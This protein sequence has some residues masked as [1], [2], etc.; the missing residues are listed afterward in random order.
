MATAAPKLCP[1]G[2]IRPANTSCPKCGAGSRRSTAWVSSPLYRTAAWRKRAR[3]QLKREPLCCACQAEGKSV[4][5]RVADHTQPWTDANSF[6][7]GDLQ[8]LCFSHHGR[9]SASE[10]QGVAT[11][12]LMARGRSIPSDGGSTTARHSVCIPSQIGA[13]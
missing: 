11:Q 10:R 6:W 13:V 2:S 8:S 12:G 4:V 3:A 7:S 9:K 5:A 1:C